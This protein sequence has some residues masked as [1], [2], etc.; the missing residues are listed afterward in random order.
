MSVAGLARDVAAKVGVG[1]VPADPPAVVDNPSG[2]V[3]WADGGDGGRVTGAGED[4]EFAVDIAA[5]DGCGR[6]VARVLRGVDPSAASPASS[7]THAWR[8]APA[9]QAA[10]R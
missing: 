3:T 7:P 6:F 9:M 8:N 1:F 2:A 10:R 4:V 5:P